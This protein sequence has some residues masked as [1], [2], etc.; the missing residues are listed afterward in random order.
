MGR[1]DLD[2]GLSQTLLSACGVCSS[3]AFLSGLSERGSP[4]RLQVHRDLKF[5][6]REIIMRVLLSSVENGI[7]GGW[8][9]FGGSDLDQG[10]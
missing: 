9:D 7:G 8:K 4:Q 1:E 6:G 3:W 10:S 5:Q 2:Q